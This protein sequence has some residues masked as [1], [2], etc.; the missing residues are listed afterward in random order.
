MNYITIIVPADEYEEIDVET[1][2]QNFPNGSTFKVYKS[3][4]VKEPSI[5]LPIDPT[6]FYR[7]TDEVTELDLDRT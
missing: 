5:I 1:L 6:S 4:H 2:T 7:T 3:A